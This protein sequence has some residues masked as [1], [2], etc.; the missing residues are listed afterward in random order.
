MD[1]S[2]VRRLIRS[3][4]DKAVGSAS[5]KLRSWLSS[6][7]KEKT[8]KE[9]EEAAL[10]FTRCQCWEHGR[11]LLLAL[12][13]YRVDPKRISAG[14]LEDI[15]TMKPSLVKESIEF[16]GQGIAAGAFG[17]TTVLSGLDPLVSVRFERGSGRLISK[18]RWGIGLELSFKTSD[19]PRYIWKQAALDFGK[20][21]LQVRLSQDKPWIGVR[22]RRS[23]QSAGFCVLEA[24]HH[25]NLPMLCVM[26]QKLIE[27]EARSHE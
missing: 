25:F 4:D 2:E 15:W 18:D 1:L 3:K 14:L 23:R 20:T 12:I 16:V 11:D 27:L 8:P 26:G 7:W 21:L 6:F 5:S 9:V 24:W 17:A 22:V 19:L 13:H 10:V